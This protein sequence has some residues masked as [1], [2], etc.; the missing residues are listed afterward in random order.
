M[1]KYV[2][3]TAKLR[4]VYYLESEKQDL[5]S[6]KLKTLAK[7]FPGR[8]LYLGGAESKIGKILTSGAAKGLGGIAGYGLFDGLGC[9]Y[10]LAT[11]I[12]LLLKKT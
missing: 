3:D 7:M 12:K 8:Q 6:I 1:G 2:W 11:G 10:W 5:L 4:Q 9:L